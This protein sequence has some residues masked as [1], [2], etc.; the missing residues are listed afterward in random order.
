MWNEKLLRKQSNIN[1]TNNTFLTINGIK[2]TDILKHVTI[3]YSKINCERE[4]DPA[5]TK[6][7][8]I[9]PPPPFCNCLY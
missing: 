7:R 8:Q 3:W 4:P 2:Y 5:S 9:L 6:S 1:K